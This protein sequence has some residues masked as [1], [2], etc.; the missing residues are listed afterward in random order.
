[1]ADTG[2]TPPPAD[3]ITLDAAA[4]RVLAHPTR[5][6]LLN[7]LR[8][9]GPATVRG[10]AAQ[11]ELDSGAASYHLRRLAAGGLIEEATE[12]G[13]KRDRWWRAVH[14]TSYHD[15]A[16]RGGAEGRAYTQ[17]VAVAAADSLRHAAAEAVPSMPEEWFA[18]TAFSDYELRLTPDEL[19]SLKD[20]LAAVVH[21][22]QDRKPAAGAASVTVQF[23][24]FPRDV[25]GR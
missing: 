7:R 6:A 17:A 16:E 18:A 24:A 10:L 21:R 8:R 23:Q 14:R 5:L 1:M 15:P 13:D 3:G 2:S 22:Y 9:D 20:E 25:T 11:F 19:A 12:L 4:L